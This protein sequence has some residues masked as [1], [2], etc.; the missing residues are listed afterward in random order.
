MSTL[1]KIRT[2]IEQYNQRPSHYPHG[3]INIELVLQI[4]DKYAEQEPTHP[5]D[6]CGFNTGEPCEYWGYC[7]AIAKKGGE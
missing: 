7:P 4:I 1:E 2:E 5:C 6:L 3:M